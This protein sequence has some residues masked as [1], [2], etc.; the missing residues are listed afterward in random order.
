MTANNVVFANFLDL[1]NCAEK[2]GFDDTVEKIK[3]FVNALDKQSLIDLVTEIGTIPE[4]ISAGSTGEKAFSKAS[5]IILA[6][7]FVELGLASN[8]VRKRSNSADIIAK[9]E[10]HGY[11]L[12]ADAKTFRLSRT[13][14]NQK[15]F[16]ISTL[17]NW[18]GAEH[19]YALVV[20]P[21]FQ[22][23]TTESQIY[24]SALEHQVCL[25]SWEHIL[26]LLQNDVVETEALSLE[27]I[28][29]ASVRLSRN[30]TLLYVNRMRNHLPH[31]NKMVCERI[32]QTINV[33][34][35]LLRL[36]KNQI[37]QRSAVEL[38]YLNNE[39]ATIK[40]LTYEQAINAL[41]DSRK[42]NERIRTIEHFVASLSGE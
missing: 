3:S 4:H 5:D 24:S 23:P 1:V 41:I 27:P 25:L 7:C 38:D 11:T 37:Q 21:Y 32:S 19:D 42:L 17:S 36:R 20:G 9:S 10:Y 16:K 35:D 8:A 2:Y 15:D 30:S 40:Q 6:R 26:F 22:Y 29:N 18:R 33:F 14:K 13:A 34:D 28:W 39:I 31:I 12:V